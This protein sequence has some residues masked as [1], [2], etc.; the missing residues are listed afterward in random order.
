M[1]ADATAIMR[2]FV[3]GL[4]VWGTTEDSVYLPVACI[5]D[6]ICCM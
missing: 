5:S 6:L 1:I 3:L 4:K 2:P